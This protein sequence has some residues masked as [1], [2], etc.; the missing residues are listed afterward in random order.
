[1]A[2]LAEKTGQYRELK[3]EAVRVVRRDREAQVRGV[4][5]TVES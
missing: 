5:E 2:T 4:F 3:G 1:M